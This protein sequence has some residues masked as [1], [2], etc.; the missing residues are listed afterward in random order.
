LPAPT[1]GGDL[2][3]L[4]HRPVH[5]LADDDI[6]TGAN[7]HITRYLTNLY[8]VTE[9]L[10]TFGLYIDYVQRNQSQ[11]GRFRNPKL[12]AELLQNA[13]FLT[14]LMPYWGRVIQVHFHTIQINSQQ[15]AAK[16]IG[17]I[18]TEAVEV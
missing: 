1:S 3:Y 14:A 9:F 2:A 5:Y 4:G 13:R 10:S 7:I 16:R 8:G 6:E 15:T 12:E 18:A 11:V 17:R